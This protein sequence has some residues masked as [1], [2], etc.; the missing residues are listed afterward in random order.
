MQHF[1]EPQNVDKQWQKS[2]NKATATTKQNC[3]EKLAITNIFST[4][5]M[6]Q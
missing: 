5:S 1:H 3:D 2:E 6:I 4:M